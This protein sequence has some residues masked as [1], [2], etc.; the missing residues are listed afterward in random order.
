ML[1]RAGPRSTSILGEDAPASI[2]GVR[3]SIVWP[4]VVDARI[5]RLRLETPAA[6]QKNGN[7][8]PPDDACHCIRL[9]QKWGVPSR[10]SF[11]IA[12]KLAAP[13]LTPRC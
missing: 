8:Q 9:D 6:A 13:V 1:D 12:M 7:E 10:G 5:H 2:V 11:Q 4:A 3:L